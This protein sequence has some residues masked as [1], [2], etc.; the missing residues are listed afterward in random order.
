[1]LENLKERG[2]TD[3]L[4]VEGR[5]ILEWILGE[6]GGKAWTVC[7]LITAQSSSEYGNVFWGVLKVGE[8][9]D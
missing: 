5:I 1:L 7:K 2:H 3:D 9:L 8:F 6:K 4:G